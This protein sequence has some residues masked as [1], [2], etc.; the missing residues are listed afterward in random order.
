LVIEKKVV[1]LQSDF[2]VDLQYKQ[3]IINGKIVH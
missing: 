3:I 2:E 1:L